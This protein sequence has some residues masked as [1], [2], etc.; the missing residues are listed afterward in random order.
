MTDDTARQD[1]VPED[2]LERTLPRIA[3]PPVGF[4]GRQVEIVE[5]IAAGHS[6]VE[7]GSHLGISARTVRM[8]CE[9]LRA[10]LRVNRSRQIPA[11]FL[12]RTGVD[13]LLALAEAD[14]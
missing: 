5:L 12:L 6:A 2:K 7:I 3:L 13:P 11:A 9:V 10:K 1:G 8:H 14:G 4:T